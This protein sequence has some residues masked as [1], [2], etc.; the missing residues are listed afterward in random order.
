[1]SETIDN[2]KD[3]VILV[4]NN[5]KTKLIVGICIVSILVFT[6]IGFTYGKYNPDPNSQVIQELLSKMLADEK[7]KYE[8]IMN[9]KDTEITNILIKLNDSIA[10]TIENEKEIAKL[11][12]KI[13][14][15]KPPQNEKEVRSRLKELGYETK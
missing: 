12:T 7:S 14:S 2:L 15:I 13:N 10:K 11:K 1:M 5:S 9:Q 4:T 6:F 8:Q 3:K